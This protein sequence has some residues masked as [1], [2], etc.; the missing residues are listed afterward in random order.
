MWPAWESC[1]QSQCYPTQEQ[2]FLL[3]GK[4]NQQHLLLC[5]QLPNFETSLNDFHDIDFTLHDGL[6]DG[7]TL[8]DSRRGRVDGLYSFLEETGTVFHSSC[9][10]TESFYTYT[11]SKKRGSWNGEPKYGLQ[12]RL[13]RCKTIDKICL[14]ARAE[15]CL[16]TR[17]MHR[18]AVQA[19]LFV[20]Y[21]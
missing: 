6:L 1:L 9:N 20:S 18:N 11:Y 5:S 16:V 2:R 8:E 14:L 15:P 10:L 17:R 4:L 7:A 21:N 19:K 13:K 12:F 3:I